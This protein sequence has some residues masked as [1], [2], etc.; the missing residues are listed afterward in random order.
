MLIPPTAAKVEDD[1]VLAEYDVFLTPPM[2]E[3]I[4]L[5]QYPNR[6]RN[7]PYAAKFGATPEEMRIKPKT[8]YLEVDINLNTEHNFNKYMGLKWGDAARMSKEVHNSTGTYGPAAG[9]APGK[10]RSMNSARTVKDKAD[11][12]LDFDND[13][14]AFKE[15]EQANKVH[16]KQTLG[17][18]IVKHDA[19]AE[20]GK[21]SYFVGAFQ[22]EQLHLT[23]ISGTVQM[24]P[25]FHHVD[26]EE[27]RA[28]LAVSRAQAEAGTGPDPIARA[29]HQRTVEHEEKN[30][31]E[32]RLRKLLSLAAQEPWINMEYVDEDEQLAFDEFNRKLKVENTGELPHLRSE[33][34]N[35]EFLDAISAPKH[36]SPTRRRKRAARRR[37]AVELQDNDA[38]D[39]GD[40]DVEAG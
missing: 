6:P 40:A 31:T 29:V 9:L 33:M 38:D 32:S 27:Q 16:H 25:Q 19:E 30:S 14:R 13:L 39:A 5:L 23:K 11:R 4:Y 22:G 2:H 36:G 35:D 26:A 17:G 24:R 1:P 12:E 15:A 18:Q 37:E 20:M 3:Q 21:P 8:G 34:N 10:V 7:R 28:R